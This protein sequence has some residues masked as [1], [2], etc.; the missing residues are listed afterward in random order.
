MRRLELKTLNQHTTPCTAPTLSALRAR[1]SATSR[2]TSHGRLSRPSPP[3]FASTRPTSTGPWTTSP[4]GCGLR[5]PGDHARAEPL[6]LAFPA[7]RASRRTAK[8]FRAKPP[9]Y[10]V[11]ARNGFSGELVYVGA[12][13]ADDIDTIFDRKLDPKGTQQA[14]AKGKIVISEGYASPGL[15]SQFEEL[16]AVGVIAI[17]P[18]VD[19][20]WGICTTVW[21]MP[22]LD[23]LPRKPKIPVV[24]VNNPDGLG[25]DRDGEARCQRHYLHRDGGRLVHLEAPGRR[26]P[27]ARGARKIRAAARPSRQLGCRRRRQRGRRRDAARDR[28]RAVAAPR[29]ACAQ[30]ADRL[31][32][33]PLDRSLCGLDL[34]CRCVRASISKKTASR[35][36]TA[37]APAAVGRRS[38]RTSRGC[39]RPMLSSPK[40]S[41]TSRTSRPTASVRTAPATTRST[42]SASRATSCCRRR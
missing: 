41:A 32:A 23:D 18:G 36:S 33:R 42:T 16:G 4:S 2:S 7:R 5:R 25:L 39:R 26:D 31:V 14:R 21:G 40:S 24:A 22:D 37:T 29:Q 28:A 9:A 27:G 20:H 30:R 3:G 6:P 15:V 12:N 34:V 19:I 17:N 11:D 10:C 13:Q 35:R 38:S 8:T 1:F